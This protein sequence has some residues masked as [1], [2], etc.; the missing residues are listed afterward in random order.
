MASFMERND[1]YSTES[2]LLNRMAAKKAEPSE[3]KV[4]PYRQ[5][6]IDARTNEE[7]EDLYELKQEAPRK[8]KRGIQRREQRKSRKDI[9]ENLLDGSLHGFKP[10]EGAIAQSLKRGQAKGAVKAAL[11]ADTAAD[12][13]AASPD[14]PTRARKAANFKPSHSESVNFDKLAKEA[15]AARDLADQKLAEQQAF[16]AAASP[17]SPKQ[18]DIGFDYALESEVMPPTKAPQRQPTI[19][20]QATRAPQAAPPSKAA[21]SLAGELSGLGLTPPAKATPKPAGAG[22][23]RQQSVSVAVDGPRAAQAELDKTVGPMA[24]SRWYF[25]NMDRGEFEKAVAACMQGD[26]LVRKSGS[27]DGFVL[28]VNDF[29]KPI[30]FTINVQPSDGRFEFTGQLFRTLEEV[31]EYARRTPLKSR[32][33][34][35]EQLKLGSPAVRQPWF[36]YNATR[37]TCEAAVKAGGHGAFLVRMSSSGDKYVL[38][39]NDTASVCSYTIVKTVSPSGSRFA[40]GG[41]VHD[42]VEELI[43]HIHTKPFQSKVTKTMT[44]ATSAL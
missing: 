23:R 5:E 44:L 28:C 39:L 22:I 21:L 31:I 16:D 30:N 17:G 41:S 43:T 26:F 29:T 42:S 27:T 11:A 10:D 36:P 40:F 2:E 33:H 1:D 13:A 34:A 20:Q 19:I 4:A 24:R 37:E 15:Q 9:V 32:M 14:T 8:H 25:E 38:V 7:D 18:F 35:G 6:Q 3:T 12:A